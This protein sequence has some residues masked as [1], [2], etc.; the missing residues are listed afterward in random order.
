MENIVM[1][2]KEWK[3]WHISDDL[4]ALFE[5]SSNVILPDTRDELIDLSVGG[6]G[7]KTYKVGYEIEGIYQTDEEARLNGE[8]TKHAGD[9]RYKEIDGKPG[10]TTGDKTILANTQPKF[11]FGLTNTINWNNFELSFLVTVVSVEI[12]LMNLIRV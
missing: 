2:E 11:T 3:H 9:Y 5:K 7:N 6:K 12:L 1:Q 8:A 4:K 10:I